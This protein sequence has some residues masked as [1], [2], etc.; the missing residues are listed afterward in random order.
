MSKNFMIIDE[1]HNALIGIDWANNKDRTAY[2]ESNKRSITYYVMAKGYEQFDYYKK[3]LKEK[4]GEDN[5][6]VYLSEI[7][8]FGINPKSSKIIKCGQWWENKCNSFKY[9]YIIKQFEEC[10]AIIEFRED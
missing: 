5:K 10:G 4:F 2:Y 6:F 8:L 1:F 7:K 3:L 9:E